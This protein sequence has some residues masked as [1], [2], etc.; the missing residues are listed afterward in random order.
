MTA[1]P[2]D[3]TEAGGAA[4][5]GIQTNFGNNPTTYPESWKESE[6]EFGPYPMPGTVTAKPS[7]EHANAKEQEYYL[8]DE[9]AA[10]KK[11]DHKR[12]AIDRTP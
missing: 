3:P 8:Q 7:K 12:K 9:S 6:G 10:V 11:G 2:T 4:N 5:E 1:Q